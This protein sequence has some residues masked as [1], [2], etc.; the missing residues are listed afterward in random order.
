[1][2]EL[3]PL[4]QMPCDTLELYITG[5]V[6]L[7]LVLDR[8]QASLNCYPLCLLCQGI[9]LLLSK[10]WLTKWLKGFPGGTVVK[11]PLSNAG[12]VGSSPGSGRS[13]EKEIATHSSILAWEIPWTKESDTLQSIV[14]QRVGH[15]WETKQQQM[16]KGG[17]WRT[18]GWQVDLG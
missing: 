10:Y 8:V 1:M 7:C 9:K 17:I 12:D 3:H 13:L 2:S 11:N 5:L 14:L 4:F 15:S 18:L 6:T 16:T